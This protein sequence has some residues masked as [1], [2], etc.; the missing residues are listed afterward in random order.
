MVLFMACVGFA[1]EGA[2]QTSPE[3]LQPGLNLKF[4]VEKN[5]D[6]IGAP[7]VWLYVPAAQSPT[8]FLPAGKF[9]A[10]WTG[11]IQADLRGDFSFQAEWNGAFQLAI[12]GQT[13]LETGG[14]N[15]LSELSQAIRLRKGTNAFTATFSSATRGDSMLRLLWKPADSFLQPIPSE[16]FVH[17]VTS[18]E[19]AAKK[20]RLGRELFV[21]HR[22]GKCHFVA[23]QKGM[24]EL[25][26]D[27]P[28]FEKIGARRN[29]VWLQKWIL[30]PKSLRLIAHMPKLF[31]GA[32]AARDAVDVADFLA[33]L[34]GDVETELKKTEVGKAEAG[35]NLFQTLHCA[36]CHNDPESAETDDEKIDLKQVGIK[37]A[38]GMLVEFLR[39]PNA[40]YAWIRMPRFKLADEQFESL[41]AYLLSKSE[42]ATQRREP[43]SSANLA[44][45]KKLAQTSGCLN[46]HALKLE[47]E[48]S[49]KT[50]AQ[51]SD[52]DGGCLAKSQKE[53]STAPQFDFTAEQREALQRLVATDRLS[54][55]RHDPVEFSER[56]S[57]QLRCAECHGKIEGIPRFEIL[58]G[59]LKPEWAG[60]FI[61]GEIADKPRP[62]LDA[63]M[64]AFATQ[65]RLLA[66]GLALQHGLPPRTPVEKAGDASLA[67]V[68]RKL[69]SIPPLGFSCVSCHAVG[70]VSATQVFEAPGINLAISGERLQPD[71]FRRWL[72]APSRIDPI[73]KMPT[74]FDEEGKSPLTEIFDGDGAKQIDAIWQYLWLG[75]KNVRAKNAINVRK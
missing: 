32:N 13:V 18:E 75:F 14:S 37:F 55:S 49:T 44:R 47:N 36:A 62:W 21:E 25:E 63:Q 51:L 46:C 26:M 11:F 10:T 66:D 64:P 1:N 40:H 71:F 19:T 17:F 5:E 52:G 59:K 56:Q 43:A 33:S 20:L 34:E 27:A 31:H 53:N 54:L 65:A 67:E 61:A 45:G 9:T 39:K 58:G 24:P 69:V 7:N 72:R 60:K 48:F 12:N 6:V 16:A 29:F 30:H 73:T 22:C 3:K 4:T 23:S 42:R 41:A 68:G 70:D 28:A 38:P 8:P 35:R 15:S 2:T 50:L 74:Y 57:R